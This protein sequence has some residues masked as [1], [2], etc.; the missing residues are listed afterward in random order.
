MKLSSNTIFKD[1][2]EQSTILKNKLINI[3]I[4]FAIFFSHPACTKM[5]LIDERGEE[6]TLHLLTNLLLAI[7]PCKIGDYSFSK[8]GPQCLT[9]GATGSGTLTALGTKSDFVSMTLGFQLSDTNSSLQIVTGGVPEN[10]STIANYFL[11]TPDSTALVGVTSTKANV[12]AGNA[13]QSW[14]FETHF[15]ESPDHLVLDNYPCSKKSISAALQD[16]EGQGIT[17]D[18]SGGPWGFVLHNASLTGLIVND[19]EVFSE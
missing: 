1:S 4:I 8:N 7:Q 10:N 9:N 17:R 13:N 2:P 6:D 11:M 12:T 19:S 15:S 14:C 18:T 5:G 16:A 3:A